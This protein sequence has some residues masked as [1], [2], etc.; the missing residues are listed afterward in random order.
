MEYT[1]E[2]FAKFL[3]KLGPLDKDIRSI[4]SAASSMVTS[5]ESKEQ[6]EWHDVQSRLSQ[7]QSL[8]V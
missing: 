6:S 1:A 8:R 5:R 4:L 3:T 7:V 2:L